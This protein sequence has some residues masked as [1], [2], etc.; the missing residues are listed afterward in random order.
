MSFTSASARSARSKAA[1]P[2]CSRTHL[3]KFSSILR[4]S[5][6]SA[7]LSSSERSIH[8]FSGMLSTSLRSTRM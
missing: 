3:R 1:S 5:L 8:I 6:D 4:Y 7:S 2:I